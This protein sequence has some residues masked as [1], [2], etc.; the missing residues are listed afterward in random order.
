[1]L[2][3]IL[4]GFYIVF[5]GL[6]SLDVFSPGHGFWGT[7]LALLIHLIP[8]FLLIACLVVAWKRETIGGVLFLIMGVVFT[9]FFHTY[10]RP[11]I[12]LI[13]SLPLILIGALFVISGAKKNA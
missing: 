2:P 9:L 3:R 10:R 8:S 4:T 11:D 5:L 7:I 1:M 12:F 13:I 6:F